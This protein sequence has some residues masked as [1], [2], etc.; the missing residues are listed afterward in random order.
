M[1]KTYYAVSTPI[2]SGTVEKVRSHFQHPVDM[3]DYRRFSYND[4]INI[5][6]IHSE[7]RL[8]DSKN[9]ANNYAKEIEIL[10]DEPANIYLDLATRVLTSM[11]LPDSDMGSPLPPIKERNLYQN[12]ILKI[13]IKDGA[14]IFMPDPLN[15]PDCL[16]I[17]SN[18]QF[19]LMNNNENYS[20]NNNVYLHSL[21]FRGI[22]ES[23]S[24]TYPDKYYQGSG[25]SLAQA[26]N[27][28]KDYYAP[29]FGLFLTG[30]WNR[31]HEAEA[32]ELYEQI[33]NLDQNAALE[34]LWKKRISLINSKTC[35]LEGSFFKRISYATQTLMPS[36]PHE[37][38][39]IT[40]APR[41]S[42]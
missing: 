18:C 30:H 37:I 12:I 2:K 6:N 1:P 26:T 41:R 7:L 22:T 16:G 32:K 35:N 5:V 25:D 4:L 21:N 40:H 28:I 19:H 36:E 11:I 29:K 13:T 20:K 39:R 15:T 14:D 10:E 38:P 17:L 24:F 3:K 27:L 23:P 8:F 9:A 33:R 42:M 34:H 31:H